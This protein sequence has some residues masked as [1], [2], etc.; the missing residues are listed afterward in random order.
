MFVKQVFDAIVE[1][2]QSVKSERGR[3]TI[4]ASN[5]WAAYTSQEGHTSVLFNMSP[6]GQK[7]DFEPGRATARARIA[8]YQPGV[9]PADITTRTRI[10]VE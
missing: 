4:Q 1:L 9:Q 8:N 3:E 2:E 6:I 5:D 7:L 10:V